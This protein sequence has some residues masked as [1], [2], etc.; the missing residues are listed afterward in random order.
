MVLALVAR[1]SVEEEVSPPA[2][3]ER[4]GAAHAGR[5]SVAHAWGDAC[6]RMRRCVLMTSV[7]GIDERCVSAQGIGSHTVG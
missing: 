3:T 1:S 4:R 6:A 2:E 7:C 5:M